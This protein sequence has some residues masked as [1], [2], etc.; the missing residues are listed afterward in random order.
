MVKRLLV[1]P[2]LALILVPAPSV[3]PVQAGEQSGDDQSRYAHHHFQNSNPDKKAE[4]NWL[5]GLKK[6]FLP[7]KAVGDQ[8]QETFPRLDAASAD[9]KVKNSDQ[10][11]PLIPNE[12]GMELKLLVR[13]LADRVLDNKGTSWDR[14]DFTVVV[15]TF[16]DLN[17]LYRTSDLGRL[18]AEQMIGELQKKGIKIIDVRF[19]NSLQVKEG[20]GEYGLSRE[21]S[22][23]S[24]VHQAQARMVGTYSVADGQ[25]VINARILG[26]KDGRALSSGT[27][28]LKKN[29]MVSE[30]LK[31]SGRPVSP[32]QTV[33]IES[34]DN[35]ISS[36]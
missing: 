23:L 4:G 21:M 28:I 24:Y 13:E 12:T 32:L 16:V 14:Q 25:V 33:M 17:H 10:P 2:L 27:I 15:S 34:F 22:E 6:I 29:R 30:L 7:W 5:D 3:P 11:G 18:L 31:N 26:Q 20:G 19:A 1:L 9:F 35:I 8:A 36:Q